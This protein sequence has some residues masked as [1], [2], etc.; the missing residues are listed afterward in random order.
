AVE[1]QLDLA[2][3]SEG[4]LQISHLQAVG[5]N[6]WHLQAKAIEAIEQARAE[7]VDVE[8]DC[9]P[10][11][12]GS[13]VLTQVLPQ[14]ALDGGLPALMARLRDSAKRHTIREET[15][16]VIAWRWSDIHISSVGS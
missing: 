13:S 10:Y 12:A 2:R 5:A 6:N 4:R 7:G 15:L 3:R 9:Y 11:V 1:E 14:S 16:R 8:F